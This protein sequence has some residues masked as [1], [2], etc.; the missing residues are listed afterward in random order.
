LIHAAILQQNAS[1]L[2]MLLQNGANPNANTLSTAEE[3]KLSP[4]YLAASLGWIDGL[5]MLAEAR[6]DMV[7]CRGFGNRQRTTLHGA[8]E[9]N[10]I[11]AAQVV[12]MYTEG[13]LTNIPDANG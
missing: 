2:D 12:T 7:N 10:H 8:V 4:C 9:K 5:H 6:A 1:V 11:Q 13:V 3:D